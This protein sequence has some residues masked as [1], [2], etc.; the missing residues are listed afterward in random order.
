MY[1]EENISH[2][3]ADH[4]KNENETLSHSKE[5]DKTQQIRKLYVLHVLIETTI[6]TTTKQQTNPKIICSAVHLSKKNC[7]KRYKHIITKEN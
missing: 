5:D 7:I 4:E 1:D 6:T 3:D 2:D